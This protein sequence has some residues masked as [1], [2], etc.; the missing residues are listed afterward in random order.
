MS[1]V[2]KN[3]ISACLVVHN[4]EKLIR[5]CLESIK[6][7]V[8]EIIVIHDGPCGD[9][10]LK[11]ARK[12]TNNIFVY[13]FVGVAEPH[14]VFGYKKAIGNWILSID[15]DEFLS[16]ELRKNLRKLVKTKGADAYTF[17]WPIWRPEKK[18]YLTKN[19]PHK[20]AL[21]RKSKMYFLGFP[22]Q[23]PFTYGKLVYTNLLFEHRPD[24]FQ[25][26]WEQF[27]NK[28]LK[29]T[30]MQARYLV[31]DFKNI[32]KFQV[33]EKD[34]NFYYQFKRKFPLLAIP[35]SSAEFI[36]GGIRLGFWKEG[37]SAWRSTIIRIT[38][39]CLLWYY[40]WKLK[41]GFRI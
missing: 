37:F 8:D 36:L 27:L 25:W 34:W 24:Y 4:E 31:K 5:R 17:I 16:E 7:V 13:P 23:H 15:A 35:I 22:N 40:V 32:P 33:K 11:I 14:R 2:A 29:W 30:K 41:H 10:T 18:K 9:K 6:D 3:S 39:E 1:K 12:Y 20:W 21:F 19:S 26:T 28:H 38:R